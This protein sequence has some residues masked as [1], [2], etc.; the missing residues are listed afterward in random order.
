M[1]VG[2]GSCWFLYVNSKWTIENFANPFAAHFISS[3]SSIPPD[4][5]KSRHMNH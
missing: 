5:V 3:F 1:K 2:G 4:G